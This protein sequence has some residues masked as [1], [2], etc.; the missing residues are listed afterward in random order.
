M[1]GE[2]TRISLE[3][4]WP[5]TPKGT[6]AWKPLNEEAV[7]G[8]ARQLQQRQMVSTQ[9]HPSPSK[10]TASLSLAW[11][12]CL[13]I[14]SSSKQILGPSLWVLDLAVTRTQGTQT[15]VKF[16]TPKGIIVNTVAMGL[17]NYGS[18]KRKTRQKDG[19][20]PKPHFS[21]LSMSV[22]HIWLPLSSFGSKW[23]IFET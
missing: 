11:R 19:I 14:F 22:N 6:L 9:R 20:L 5:V 1:G 21:C 23:P 4:P 15:N 10:V 2:F 8:H 18:C 7:Q 17:G 3:P 16:R 12:D 13:V